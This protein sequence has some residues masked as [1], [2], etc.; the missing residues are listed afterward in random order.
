MEVKKIAEGMTATEVA[1]IINGSFE[2]L[3]IEKANKEETDAKLSELG[4]IVKMFTSFNG[5]EIKDDKLSVPTDATSV[6]G[7]ISAINPHISNTVTNYGETWTCTIDCTSGVRG[8]LVK[9]KSDFF[10]TNPNDYSTFGIFKPTGE[11]IYHNN[12]QGITYLLIR[13]TLVVRASLS[14]SSSESPI[15]YKD[16]QS[17]D[18]ESLE[19][20]F[21]RLEKI[22]E[23]NNNFKILN[24]LNGCIIDDSKFSTPDN[25]TSDSGVISGRDP[26]ITNT[27]TEY[28]TTVT[29]QIDGSSRTKLVKVRSDFFGDTANAYSTLAIFKPDGECLYNNN[30]RGV[31][32]ILVKD[33]LVIRTVWSGSNA[34]LVKPNES[35]DGFDIEEKFKELE[36]LIN[37][38]TFKKLNGTSFAT[39]GDSLSETGKWQSKFEEL[40]GC[41]YVSDK[42][43]GVRLNKGGTVTGPVFTDCG[44]M[45]MKNLAS[46]KD[47]LSLDFIIYENVNDHDA[48]AMG[49]NGIEGSIDDEPWM[50]GSKVDYRTSVFGSRSELDSFLSNNFQS[51]LAETPSSE[52]EKG[53]YFVF[54]YF[55]SGTNSSFRFSVKE[56]AIAEGELKLY[57]NGNLSITI[58]VTTSMSLDDIASLIYNSNFGSGSINI[59]EPNNSVVVRLAGSGVQYTI[60]SGDTGILVNVEQVNEP[61]LVPRLFTGFLSEEWEDAEKWKESVSLYSLYKG[62]IEYTK[63][64][65]SLAKLYWMIPNLYSVSKN[66]SYINSDGTFNVSAYKKT[67]LSIGWER[68]RKVVIDVCELYNVPVLDVDKNSN[69]SLENVFSFFK[70]KDVH[71]LTEGYYRWGETVNSLL[72]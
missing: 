72:N 12:I 44:M 30:V 58:P 62:L 59:I 40:S 69:I 48:F 42:E 47:R 4:S 15:L 68:L 66:S 52:R 21:E 67:A 51:I 10:G 20:M 22:N 56:S 11:C 36:S 7:A 39:I 54:A 63:T 24:S 2:T 45:R 3:N 25:V 31:T 1:N 46:I 55:K 53:G 23:L 34:I 28:G 49:E 33:I 38:I 61:V 14:K 71:P 60:D 29:C 64:E 26:H 18:G 9:I 57:K 50:Q 8:K 5:R 17:N 19:E 70:E 41:H 27:I 65:F 37:N 35:K 16:Y 13:E 43:L 32:Y 6:Q